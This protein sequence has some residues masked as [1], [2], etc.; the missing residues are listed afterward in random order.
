MDH[1]SHIHQLAQQL[2]DAALSHHWSALT[3]LDQELAKLLND[4][5]VL[6]EKRSLTD[7]ERVA[8][9]RLSRAHELARECCTRELT[10]TGLRMN[11]MHQQRDGWIAYAANSDWKEEAP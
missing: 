2:R 10:Q 5:G 6:S 11:A 9:T 8:L 4:I 3:V 7:A 1:L